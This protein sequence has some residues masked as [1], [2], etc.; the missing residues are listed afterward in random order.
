MGRMFGVECELVVKTVEGAEVLRALDRAELTIDELEERTHL[1]AHRI[2]KVTHAMTALG[3]L[4][5]G[6]GGM[7]VRT[8]LALLKQSA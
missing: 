4:R 5:C 7:F 3:I 8:D 1:P 6:Q 2:A